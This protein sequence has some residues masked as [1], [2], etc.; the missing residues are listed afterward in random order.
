[1][2]R[3][4][5]ITVISLFLLLP[6]LAHA[7]P[8]PI[9][10]GTLGGSVSEG[11]GIND[12]GQVVGNSTLAGDTVRHAFVWTSETG[13]VDLGTLGG[14]N[15]YAFDINDA[16]LVV[17]ISD[18]PG[19]T[20]SH[21]FLWS[22]A[23]GMRDLGTL[24]GTRSEAI[25]VNANGQVLGNSTTST[26]PFYRPFFWTASAGIVEIETPDAVRPIALALND[27]GQ[28]IGSML[29]DSSPRGFSW[30]ATDGAVDLGTLGGLS[31]RPR[32][33]ND[34]GQV[35]GESQIAVGSTHAFFWSAA[36]GM[37][38]LGG[39]LSQANVV[40]D[41]GEVAGM[42]TY[43]PEDGTF[44]AFVWTETDG[45]IELGSLGGNWTEPFAISNNG[46][47]VGD[48]T[49]T[50]SDAGPIWRA[51]SWTRDGGIV[52]LGTLGGAHSGARAV[53]ARG[54][55]L[56]TAAGPDGGLRATL[57]NTSTTAAYQFSG[58]YRL[59][60]APA[61]NS[62]IAGR[63]ISFAFGLGGD[64]GLGIFA[65]GG[66]TSQ[67]I[68]CDASAV[69]DPVEQPIDAASSQLLYKPEIDRYAYTWKTD[70]AWAGTCRQFNLRLDDGTSHVALFSFR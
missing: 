9:D 58:F 40:N 50:G 34:A 36:G 26:D 16:G 44:H 39:H 49:I 48:A 57:W 64:F 30:T 43:T 69:V 53:N 31:T 3:R 5:V 55:V 65:S 28:V 62:A 19:D 10:L 15:S 47:I 33:L 2:N 27:S 51:F 17:G 13:I 4:S 8:T 66:P 67:P 24:G 6:T 56:G 35:V 21:A 23:D 68:A 20:E 61:F 7:Q 22:M 1:M 12:N 42:R 45:L 60:N 54:Q 70:A 46:Q 38:D 37:T 25:A 14:S 52:N 63:G 32:A 18:L 41:R 11:I 29:V 59:E